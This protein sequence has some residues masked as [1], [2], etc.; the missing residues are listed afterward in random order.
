MVPESLYVVAMEAGFGPD[1]LPI[2][3]DHPG[4]VTPFE[5]RDPGAV[6]RVDIAE[7]PGA[8]QLLDVLSSTEADAILRIA[9]QL[10]F[11]LDAPV[12]LPYEVR[13]NQNVN[14]VVSPTIDSVLWERSKRLI[15]ERVDGRSATGLNARFRFYRYSPGDYFKP[16]TDGSWTGSRVIDGTLV[17]DAYPGQLSRYS[18]LIFLT[19]GYEGGRTQFLVTTRGPHRP[20]RSRDDIS[21]VE[22]RTPKGG[23]LC[24]PHGHHPL[25]CVHASEPIASGTKCI[26]RSDVLFG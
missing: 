8:F 2:W 16:H 10:G 21:L 14:W 4:A 5:D 18:Y 23:V 25:H 11:H 15:P 24:F 12:S 13:H 6:Q 26:I 20:A 3:T 19:D 22:V 9:E 17:A 1:P 7:V